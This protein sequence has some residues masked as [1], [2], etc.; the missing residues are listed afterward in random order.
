MEKRTKE[1][2]FY[3]KDENALNSQKDLRKISQRKTKENSN[4]SESSK[5]ERRRKKKEKKRKEEV[6]FLDF[7][8]KLLLGSVFP[9][10]S[11]C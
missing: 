6:S 10:F 7:F 2:M 5:E 4:E 9:H 8:S 1:K 11:G 3:K